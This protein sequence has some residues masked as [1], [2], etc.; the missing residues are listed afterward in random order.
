MDELEVRMP[1]LSD[2]LLMLALLLLVVFS[3]WLW[4]QAQRALLRLVDLG[5]YRWCAFRTTRLLIDILQ[6]LP[7]SASARSPLERLKFYVHEALGNT[8][9]AIEGAHRLATHAKEDGCW[10]CANG[11]VNLFINAG[12]Y[13]E[14]LDIEKG[15]KHPL[16]EEVQ[17]Q[18][19]VRFNLVEAVY[20]LGDWSAASMRLSE[21][22]DVA[23]SVPFLW[24][25]FPIQKAWILAHSGDGESALVAL[26]A[27]D[28]T[29]IP[30]PYQSE[31]HY[32]RAAALLAVHRY[33]E[34]HRAALEGLNSAHRAA[35]Q[36]N[37][38]FMRGRI[39]LA[40]G[41]LEEALRC[42]E[43]GAKHPYKGQ[44]GDALLA[45][46]E[47]LGKLG[48]HE[49]ARKVLQLVLERDSQSSAARQ[50]AFLLRPDSSSPALS[51]GRTVKP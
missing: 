15:W 32:A 40:E 1:E 42:F 5:Y 39:F 33:E 51:P 8:Q 22:E 10:W 49:E 25:F 26:D 37:G 29:Q 47:C 45:W 46:G 27:V 31:F 41:R 17:Q 44:G 2:Q 6:F 4:Q 35:S 36:R 11:A 48:R 19:L 43:T 16:D 23:R 24:N 18:A 34:A 30:R 21:L 28:W 38:L 50:A 14:A 7:L 3:P 9:A 12:L 13:Q 20:N